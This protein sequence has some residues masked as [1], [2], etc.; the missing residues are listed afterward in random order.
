[1]KS[2]AHT[3]AQ[4][5]RAGEDVPLWAQL[6]MDH[7]QASSLEYQIRKTRYFIFFSTYIVLLRPNMCHM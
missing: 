6:V 2:V 3:Q 4:T 5:E 7:R 1:M